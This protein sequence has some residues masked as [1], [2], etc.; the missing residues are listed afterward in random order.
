V[1]AEVLT[2]GTELLLGQVLDTNALY[3]GKKLAGVGV[4]L[5]FKTT[6]GDNI[7]RVKSALAA[8][9]NRA[10]LIIITGGL[11]PTV[12]DITREAVA[13][14][15]NRPLELD[16]AALIKLEGLFKARGIN[17]T[18]NNRH[19]AYLP[20][21]AAPIENNNGTAP[22]FILEHNSKIIVTM[23]GVPSE[24][25]PMMEESVIPYIIKKMG[26]VKEVIVSRSLKVMGLGESRADDMIQDLFRES[27]NPSIGIYAHIN[28]IEVRL[29][30]KA[31]SSE[32]ALKLI[33]G[34]KEKVY[35]RLGEHIYGEEDETLEKKIGEIL[36]GLKLTLSTAE[37]CTCGL[38]A[39]S[40]TNVPG[41]SAYYMGGVN[42]YANS[43]KTD[44]LGVP[45]AIIEKYGAVSRECAL[46]MALAAARLFK[47]DCSISVTGIAGPDGGTVDKPVGLVYMGINVKGRVEVHK[48]NFPGI[49]ENIR[50]RSA[51]TAL[52][53]FYKSVKRLQSAGDRA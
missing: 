26:G 48:T 39:H 9:C 7:E 15:S 4:N 6:A 35:G 30:A 11:G 24:M 5:Y 36:I 52:Y 22:G 44:V 25:N 14:F 28:E 47:T 18:A 37:S 23:P 33:D 1:N 46:E 8:A 49:R 32:E 16:N 38:V 21:G 10:D 29:T 41:S 2:I 19:Q 42:S 20:K 34:L 27:K 17:M 45:A 50:V 12:D 40:V 3:L 13:Q 31:G 53:H 43:A 51:R